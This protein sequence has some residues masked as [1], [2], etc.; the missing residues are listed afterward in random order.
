MNARPWSFRLPRMRLMGR[1]YGVVDRLTAHFAAMWVA[2]QPM[3][4]FAPAIL[5]MEPR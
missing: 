3:I 4:E 1:T 2:A 5:A